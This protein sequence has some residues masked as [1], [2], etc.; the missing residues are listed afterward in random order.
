VTPDEHRREAERLRREHPSDPEAQR[1]AMAHEQIAWVIEMFK[2][3]E[4]LWIATVA[5][6]AFYLLAYFWTGK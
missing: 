1:S 6:L 3:A 4:S 2:R 5:I